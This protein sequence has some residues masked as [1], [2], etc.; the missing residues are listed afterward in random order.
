MFG[1]FMSL[2]IRCEL[3]LN[4]VIVTLLCGQTIKQVSSQLRC[5]CQCRSVRGG[6]RWRDVREGGTRLLVKKKKTSSQGNDG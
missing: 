2:V 3:S 6:R 5:C 4:C 1:C